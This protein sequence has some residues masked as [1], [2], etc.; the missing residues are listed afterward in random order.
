MIP[1]EIRGAW[2]RRSIAVDGGTPREPAYVLWLQAS[3]SFADLRIPLA[4]AGRIEAFAGTT[5]WD[6]P[7][8]TWHHA[9]D[10]NGGFADYD[11]GEVEWRG[12]ALVERGTFSDDG[13]IREYEEIWDRLDPG[14]EYLAL[15]SDDG[16]LVQVGSFSLTM[17]DGR[18]DGSTFDVRT[19]EWSADSGWND[20]YVLGAGNELPLASRALA[21]AEWRLTESSVAESSRAP[22]PR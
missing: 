21:H 2:R 3:Q 1:P 22:A 12:E 17:R 10:W 5:R 8:L 16:I 11:C 19:A 18:A 9:I 15:E 14:A 6:S 4:E 13:R 7:R 20:T